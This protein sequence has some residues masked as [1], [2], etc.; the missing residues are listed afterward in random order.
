MEL[1]NPKLVEGLSLTQSRV[2]QCH[3]HVVAWAVQHVWGVGELR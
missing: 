2:S 3:W 1:T